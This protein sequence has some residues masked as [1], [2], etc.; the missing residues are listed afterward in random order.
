MTGDRSPERSGRNQ[1]LLCRHQPDLA[2]KLIRK[3]PGLRV[4]FVS[5]YTDE[6][7]ARQG[8]LKP[9]R[10]FMEKPYALEDLL[11]RVRELLDGPTPYPDDV[12]DSE[13]T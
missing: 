8:L 10:H 5:G 12:A 7:V 13:V 9:G 2:R 6:M 4:L 1:T 11:A 3:S